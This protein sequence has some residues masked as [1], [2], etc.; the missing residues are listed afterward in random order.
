[1]FFG[2]FSKKRSGLRFKGGRK[3][4]DYLSPTET[5]SRKIR[6]VRE[7]FR[8]MF[9]CDPLVEFSKIAKNPKNPITQKQ[10]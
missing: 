10:R 4:E 2:V 8:G 9:D 5:L 6:A 7:R 3:V 1:M